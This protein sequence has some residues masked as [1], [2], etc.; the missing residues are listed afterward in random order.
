MKAAKFLALLALCS[1]AAVAVLAYVKK[2]RTQNE[3]GVK[4]VKVV[5]GKTTVT[6]KP[7]S[8]KLNTVNV[9]K[10]AS[11]LPPQP[12]V[13]AINRIDQLFSVNGK[14]LPIVETVTYTSHVEW[15]PG[16]PAW[17]SDY[18][19]HYATS[20]HFIARSLNRSA[21]Y[22]TQ[23]VREGDHFNVL[24][25]D[26]NITFHLVVSVKDCRMLF[27]YYD[28]DTHER[29]LLKSY[30]VGL[31]RPSDSSPSGCL[32]PLG[33]FE[34]GDRI[35]IYKPHDKGLFQQKETEMIRVFGTRW[36]PFD[37]GYGIHGAPWTS[38]NSASSEE[39][40]ENRTSVGRFESDG[41]VRLLTEDVEEL[42]AIV[43]TKPTTLHIV[44][45]FSEAKLPGKE[46]SP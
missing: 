5:P 36:I 20:R 45:N 25:S 9:K 38:A 35:A 10:E 14:K 28:G 17:I 16:K 27:Y 12:S 6:A 29:V 26:K 42:F 11:P 13:T 24:R 40:I 32:T 21:D 39:L 37:K 46:V 8:Q 2:Q 31:G 43:I 34:L 4:D 3:T 7:S 41:C 22:F 30:P 23:K 33:T 18:A 44:K 19:S 1:F 15:L